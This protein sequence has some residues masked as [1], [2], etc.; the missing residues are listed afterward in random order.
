MKSV[1]L[2]FLVLLSS[3]SLFAQVSSGRTKALV[4]GIS[5]YEN[6]DIPD[7]QLPHRDAEL[8]AASLLKNKAFHPDPENILIITNADATL[9]RVSSA[10]DWL[11]EG[12]SKRDTLILYFAGYGVIGQ[13]QKNAPS[14]LFFHDTPPDVSDAG[15][16]ELFYQFAQLARLIQ[17]AFMVVGNVLPLVKSDREQLD[18]ISSEVRSK[19]ISIF[20]HVVS[21]N[22]SPSPGMEGRGVTPVQAKW[23]LNQIV[24]QGMLGSADK[25][26]DQFIRMKEFGRYIQ[27]SKVSEE[28]SPGYFFVASPH[29]N[30]IVSKLDHEIDA[31]WDALA[32]P[33]FQSII[34]PSW[35]SKKYLLLKQAGP[36]SQMLVQDF[37]V[38]I[39]LG[40]LLE[41]AGS[42][43]KEILD[44]IAQIEELSSFLNDFRRQLVAAY[45]DESQ[46]AL[47]A[48]LRADSR[49]LTR[50]RDREASYGVFAKYLAEALS[51]LGPTHYLNGI[52]MTKKLYF[53]GL[54]VRFKGQ[55]NRDRVTIHKALELQLEAL[56]FEPEASFIYN[57]LGIIYGLVEQTEAAIE[58][59]TSAVEFAPTWSIPYA[60]LAQTYMETDSRLALRLARHANR[61]S[62]ANAY[63]RQVEGLVHLGMK[64]L[65]QAERSFLLAIKY[66]PGYP[67]AYYNLAC[68]KSLVGEYSETA[69]YLEAAINSG[70]IDLD[71]VLQDPDLAGFRADGLWNKFRSVYF[72]Q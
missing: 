50:R 68:V 72:Q 13:D 47:N 7:L 54:D 4:I 67:D 59:F 5:H 43:A 33:V 57:E 30:F 10:L 66:D 35:N 1:A 65:D 39:R 42:N 12:T 44:S 38:A 31:H 18:S 26:H 19:E 40:H 61:L 15:S 64:S 58:S 14:K 29:R 55:R 8:F 32:D 56:T 23:T 53:Q 6:K 46:Q 27:S 69:K 36:H 63:T 37:K 52:L 21:R 17:P 48:Y 49:E 22:Y 62:P 16:F 2:L 24:L 34:D 41:P 9:A 25:N 11:F 3:I 60:N 28:T 51:M 20:R 45:Q 70:F 71:H